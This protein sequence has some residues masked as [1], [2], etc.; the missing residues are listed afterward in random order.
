[1]KQDLRDMFSNSGFP[2]KR[3]PENHEEEFLEKLEKVEIVKPKNKPFF[4]LKVAATIAILL[5]VTFGYY[6]IF[7]RPKTTLKAQIEQIEEE[8]LQSIRTEWEGFVKSTDDQNLINRY[9]L[10]LLRLEKDFKEI[11]K[12]WNEDETSMTFVVEDLIQNLQ[13]RLQLL[14][15]IQEHIEE[16][17]QSKTS[18][19]T[20]Y[21]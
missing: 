1:M 10:K 11:S 8:Y 3:L 13:T 6:Q 2:R 14:K 4:F 9:E 18:D 15:D 5:T 7:E 17:N 20:V 19:G 21:L 16:L 12:E